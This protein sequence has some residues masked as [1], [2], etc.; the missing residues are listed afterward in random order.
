MHSQVNRN[1]IELSDY[2]WRNFCLRHSSTKQKSTTIACSSANLA[3]QMRQFK[4]HPGLKYFY[5][6][7]K[8]EEKKAF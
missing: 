8:R 5:R 6:E 4:H 2:S 7:D 3:N 1:I